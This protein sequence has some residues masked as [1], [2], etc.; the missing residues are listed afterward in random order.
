MQRLLIFLL[1]T[2]LLTNTGI[3]QNDLF[4]WDYYSY[5]RSNNL[6]REAL[7]WLDNYPAQ[8]QNNEIIQKIYLEKAQI[9]LLLGNV[10]SAHSYFKICDFIKDTS[11]VI[12]AMR[13]AFVAKDTVAVNGYI[14]KYD[15]L[16]YN[17][18]FRISHEIINKNI[19]A[20]DS[21]FVQ[22][23][24]FGPIAY[25]LNNYKKRSPF[26]SALFSAV[27][28]GMGKL[29]A[30]KWHQARSSFLINTTFGLVLAESILLPAGNVY[31][32]FCIIV[33]SVFY[34][35][36]IWGSA[37]LAIKQDKDFYNQI[38]EDIS[39]YYFYKLFP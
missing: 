19:S 17:I 24:F 29:Y 5:L 16:L 27:I 14:S 6:S 32:G 34:I 23:D 2:G 28:P 22:N 25:R 12:N 11:L 8:Y 31:V 37:M 21:L 26:V 35:G 39:E 9:F 30:G 13:I 18:D 15:Y 36:N 7:T 4:T 1:F 10:D 33:S 20:N 38:N 3:C